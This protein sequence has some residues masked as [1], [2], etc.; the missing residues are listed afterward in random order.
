M[1]AFIVSPLEKVNG[2]SALDAL[3]VLKSEFEGEVTAIVQLFP[4]FPLP[5][6]SIPIPAAIII[7]SQKD[8]TKAH[9]TQG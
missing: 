9:P 2:Q 5:L 4:S 6:D 1:L 3:P 7:M 8:T